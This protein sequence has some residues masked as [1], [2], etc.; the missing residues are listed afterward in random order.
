MRWG[1]IVNFSS[2]FKTILWILSY[3][4]T[5][6]IVL[7]FGT[8]LDGAI[9]WDVRESQK[10]SVWSFCR[11]IAIT[12]PFKWPTCGHSFQSYPNLLYH[13]AFEIITTKLFLQKL[14]SLTQFL[15]MMRNNI[16]T[17]PSSLF[18]IYFLE[19]PWKC[20]TFF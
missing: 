2:H 11:K 13:M 8:N 3:G 17:C 5:E 9:I 18:Q 12:F 14:L 10:S 16:D 1:T 19:I 15:F 4:F 6:Q 7:Y 20:I